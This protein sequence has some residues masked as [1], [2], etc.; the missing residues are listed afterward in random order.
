MRAAST[1]LDHL[2]FKG[3]WLV[4]CKD[5]FLNAAFLRFYKG[6]T[7][8]RQKDRVGNTGELGDGLLRRRRS[9][10][11]DF[12]SNKRKESTSRTDSSLIHFSGKSNAKHQMDKESIP[13]LRAKQQ[14][15]FPLTNPFIG[16]LRNDSLGSSA[17][18]GQ[19]P[20]SSPETTRAT[21]GISVA[22]YAANKPRQGNNNFIA[23]QDAKAKPSVAS[24]EKSSLLAKSQP[25][26]LA[27][28]EE[29]GR[30]TK[31][32]EISGKKGKDGGSA[33]S[34]KRTSGSGGSQSRSLVDIM[35][36]KFGRSGSGGRSSS[37][38]KKSNTPQETK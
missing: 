33:G 20:T 6:S 19:S 38:G 26:Q 8:R 29:R 35:K 24:E 9:V 11:G 25:P 13:I 17:N 12:A 14:P 31:K 15:R 30:S 16:S 10:S 37:S 28:G 21:R 5:F 32:M 4:A 3:I 36:S 22:G 27:K 7:G 18:T 23:S 1:E 34:K 2:R